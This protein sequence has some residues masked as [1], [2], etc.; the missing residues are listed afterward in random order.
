MIDIIKHL[1]ELVGKRIWL[2]ICSLLILVI[3]AVSFTFH[4]PVSFKISSCII[5]DE[6]YQLH[7]TTYQIKSVV[8]KNGG[9]TV[10]V[11]IREEYKTLKTNLVEAAG[12]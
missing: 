1:L 8:E 9:A 6:Q 10:R 2:I 5:K 7:N 4:S 3:A 11:C 12:K